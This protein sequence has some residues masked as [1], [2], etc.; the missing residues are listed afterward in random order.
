MLLDGKRE[1]GQRGGY[2]VSAQV[3]ISSHSAHLITPFLVCVCCP[4]SGS[5]WEPIPST[6]TTYTTVP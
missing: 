1:S 2:T 5:D 6:A 4:G 3:C